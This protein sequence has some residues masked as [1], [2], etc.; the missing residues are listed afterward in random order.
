MVE[1][2]KRLVVKLCKLLALAL[3]LLAWYVASPVFVGHW[4]ESTAPWA[5]PALQVVYWPVETYF[6]NP[7]LPGGR[8][9]NE[10][11]GWCA[12]AI[13][14]LPASPAASDIDMSAR[15]NMVITDIPLRVVADNL[16]GLYSIALTPEVDGDTRVTLS[17]FASLETR[18]SEI[19]QQTGH[20]W[21]WVA[22]QIT[23][24]PRETI[25]QLAAAHDAEEKAK[26]LRGR[27]AM[28]FS[29]AAPL[30]LV[31]GVVWQFRRR[32]S[33]STAPSVQ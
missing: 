32:R 5:M 11:I 26:R 25:Q 21:G 31:A 19:E 17:T 2:R 13:E 15:T 12:R 27:I 18:L 8:A 1:P 30:L 29:A 23:I 24:G 33:V 22:G 3:F 16:V 6:D 28:V 14:N 7:Q 9:Y 4:C 10:Y 20:T